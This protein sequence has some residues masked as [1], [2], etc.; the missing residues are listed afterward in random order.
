MVVAPGA[1]GGVGRLGHGGGE[2]TPRWGRRCDPAWRAIV[3]VLVMAEPGAAVGDGAD[4]GE[5]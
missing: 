3:V 1:H 2:S 4:G 5:V